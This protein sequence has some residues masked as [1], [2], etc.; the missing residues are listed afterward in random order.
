M[1][2]SDIP[3]G[4]VLFIDANTLV[5]HFTPNPALGPACRQFLDRIARGEL[6]GFV[7]THTVSDM[8]HRLMTLEAVS[9][10]AW[11]MTGISQRL[12]RH[13]AEIQ[14]LT[15]FRQ[16]VDRVPT[17]GIQILPVLPPFLSQAAAFS[18]QFGLLS[19]D[20]LI[21]AFMRHHGLTHLASHDADFDRVPGLT[22]YGP[23]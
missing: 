21:V 9:R 19:G 8:A 12:R 1:I 4:A 18:Q 20:A 15:G 7:S 14:Q 5:Y 11:P 10:F 2:F 23:A 17:L 3:A 13:P 16:A 6:T 22:R